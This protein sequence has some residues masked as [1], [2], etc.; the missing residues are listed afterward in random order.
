MIIWL[1][2][3]PKSGNTLL[4][5]ILGAY[6]F[7]EDGEFKFDYTYK[8]G[9]FPTLEYF[10]RAGINI[11]DD[12]EIFENYI[13]AQKL[14]NKEN[15]SIKFFKTHSTYFDRKNEAVS[16]S[17][18]QNTLGAIYIVRDPRNVVT[19]YAYH[20]SLNIE[21]AA[22][23]ICNKDLFNIKTELHPETFLS[24]WRLN[25]L[26]WKRNDIRVLCIKYEDLINNKKKTLMNIFKFFQTLGM[27]KESFNIA[28]LNKII[29]ATEF[30]KMKDLEKKTEFRESIVDPKNNIKK[31]FFNLGPKNNWKINLNQDIRKKIEN[32]FK[33]EMTELGYL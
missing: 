6:F 15:K 12:K 9:Q 27:K 16:F 4:R 7:S 5:S 2:S 14:F 1:A 11:S 13:K 22:N 19:S 23:R 8:I 33:K 10:K 18:P 32:E 17:N 30:T 31:P 28:K 26:S 3:Y 24:S 21:E 29:K 25:Y 20:Y